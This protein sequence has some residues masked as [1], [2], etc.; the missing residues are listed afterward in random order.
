VEAAQGEY[1]AQQEALLLAEQSA[2]LARRAYEVGAGTLPE[3]LDS[4]RR[5]SLSRRESARTAGARLTSLVRLH[6]A[7]AAP[8]VLDD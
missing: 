4:Q 8:S 2:R 6:S 3:V 1:E 5:V 7:I